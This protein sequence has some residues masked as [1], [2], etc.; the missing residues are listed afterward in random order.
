MSIEQQDGDAKGRPNVLATVFNSNKMWGLR[1]PG[2]WV[3]VQPEGSEEREA[4][5]VLLRLVADKIRESEN[6]RFFIETVSGLEEFCRA[7]IRNDYDG[8]KQIAIHIPEMPPS[9]KNGRSTSKSTGRSFP[10]GRYARFTRL[11]SQA[12]RA[13]APKQTP[14]RCSVKIISVG[15]SKVAFDLSN[16]AESIMDLLV[17]S[18]VISDDNW[19]SVP[20]LKLE[21]IED[22]DPFSTRG[23]CT[24]VMMRYKCQES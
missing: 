10:S 9:K 6:S 18:G 8:Y 22:E 12:L 5:P 7:T 13:I 1:K 19:K 17:D 21:R 3:D 4:E 15:T 20:S 23:E 14:G 24:V 16:K 11:Y 2:I